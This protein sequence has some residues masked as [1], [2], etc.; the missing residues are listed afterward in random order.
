MPIIYKIRNKLSLL[1]FGI[2]LEYL[3]GSVLNFPYFTQVVFRCICFLVWNVCLLLLLL[4][5]LMITC[6][7]VYLMIYLGLFA[8][9]IYIVRVGRIKAFICPL[10]HQLPTLLQIRLFSNSPMFDLLLKISLHLLITYLL[11]IIWSFRI[12]RFHYTCNYILIAI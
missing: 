2:T 10:Q 6:H 7:C 3:F 1:L 11:P 9:I 8:L 4:F 5:I 12:L